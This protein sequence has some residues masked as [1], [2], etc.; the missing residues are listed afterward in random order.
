MA[1]RRPSHRTSHL[2]L[3]RRGTLVLAGVAGVVLAHGLD[4]VLAVHSV[5]ARA[6]VL[7]QTGHGWWPSAVGVALASAF[8]AVSMA[9]A[10]GAAGAVSRRAVEAAAGTF[11]RELAWMALWQGALFTG[12]EAVERVAAHRSPAELLHGSLFPLGLALQVLVAALVVAGL[13]LVERAGASVAVSFA[14]R[15]P[16]RRVPTRIG[17][18][19]WAGWAVVAG[20]AG[21]HEARGPPLSLVA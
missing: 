1:S 20:V 5:A 17:F 13:R 12:V 15:R 18:P 9:T 4:Y 8:L 10:R 21:R 19:A 6:Q 7:A 11:R 2:V 14:G 3:D 16:R